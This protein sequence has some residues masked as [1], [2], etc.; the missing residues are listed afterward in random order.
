MALPEAAPIVERMLGYPILVPPWLPSVLAVGL[1]VWN[2][3]VYRE[4]RLLDLAL[5][6]TLY[7][8]TDLL[9]GFAVYFLLWHSL[10]AG[11]QQWI[12]LRQQGMVDTFGSYLA[13]LAPLSVGAALILGGGYW[14]LHR[15]SGVGVDMGLV[16]ILISLITLPHT[17]LVDRVYR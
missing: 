17:F 3:V 16:F 2:A 13:Q 15:H 8:S 6:L 11:C 5:L 9:V 1:V 7:L 14:W 4:Q 12:Y 10:P